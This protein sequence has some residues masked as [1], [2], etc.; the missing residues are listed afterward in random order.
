MASALAAFFQLAACQ[1]GC[2]PDRAIK[3]ARTKAASLSWDVEGWTAKVTS[4]GNRWNV[5]LFDPEAGTGG[6]AF[7]AVDQRTCGVAD[8]IGYQ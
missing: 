6:Q 4:R 7:F 8:W 2:G 5:E 1:S 3:I